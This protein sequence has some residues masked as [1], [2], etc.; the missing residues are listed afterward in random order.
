ML[1]DYKTENGG[2][3]NFMFS[4]A[5]FQ[6][7]ESKGWIFCIIHGDDIKGWMGVPFYGVERAKARY[8]EM[9]NQYFTFFLLG[10]H[11]KEAML[12]SDNGEKI[13]NGNWVGGNSGSKMW[14]A[15][16]NPNQW[17]FTINEDEGIATREKIFFV[18]RKESKPKVKIYK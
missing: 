14:M 13:I 3:M 11:H 8:M 15:A 5:W 12:P 18:N 6:L 1:R 4:D 2:N 7:Y 17:M 9:L 16:N 10:H